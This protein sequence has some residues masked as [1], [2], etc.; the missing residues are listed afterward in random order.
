[1]S[2]VSRSANPAAPRGPVAGAQ[3]GPG[4][5]AR[6]GVAQTARSARTPPA[7]LARDMRLWAHNACYVR[8]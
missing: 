3:P 8:G 2:L 5:T 7:H 4:A 6:A 1:M